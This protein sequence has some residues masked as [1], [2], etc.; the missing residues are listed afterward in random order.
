MDEL[1]RRI[2]RALVKVKVSEGMEWDQACMKVWIENH[3]DLES[4]VNEKE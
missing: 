3:F 1:S 4:S 2:F